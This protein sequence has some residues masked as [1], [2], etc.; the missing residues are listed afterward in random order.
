MRRRPTIKDVA[1][2][3]GVSTAT[4]SFVLND[5][6]GQ[7]ISLQ[8]KKRVLAFVRRRGARRIKD[9][10]EFHELASIL[11]HHGLIQIHRKHAVNPA[12]VVELRKR[13]GKQDWEVKLAPPVNTVLPVAR[14]YLDK[15]WQYF[16]ER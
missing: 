7:A 8:V 16:G 4:V 5:R 15:L 10:R 12:H 14:G 11:E 3:A 6:A 13:E 2:R 1:Q 9:V